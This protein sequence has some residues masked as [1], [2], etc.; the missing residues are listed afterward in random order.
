LP[1]ASRPKAQAFDGIP[2]LALV[3]AY[4]Q[5]LGALFVHEPELG[6]APPRLLRAIVGGTSA[7]AG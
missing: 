5:A 7:L 2:R 3:R 6:L 4:A 1:F